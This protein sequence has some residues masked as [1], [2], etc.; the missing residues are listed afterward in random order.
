MSQ[1]EQ[2]VL[3]SAH[4]LSIWTGQAAMPELKKM[5]DVEPNS[6]CRLYISL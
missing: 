2:G 3:K 1:E 4:Q 5:V 6:D